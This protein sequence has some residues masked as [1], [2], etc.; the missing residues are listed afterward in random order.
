M[1]IVVKLQ[2]RGRTKRLQQQQ[3]PQDFE[4]LLQLLPAVFKEDFPERKN[5]SVSYFDT[6]REEIHVSDDED[7]SAALEFALRKEDHTLKLRISEKPPPK[8]NTPKKKEEGKEPPPS[9][10]KRGK[11]KWGAA[12][13]KSS[14]SSQKGKQMPPP[15]PPL[16]AE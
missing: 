4:G 9:R 12:S 14:N 6:E 1:S 8:D 15:P 16:P 13:T 3:V 7:I 11:N 2:H 10:S 5:I